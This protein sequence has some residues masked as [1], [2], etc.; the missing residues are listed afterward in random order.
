VEVAGRSGESVEF[1]DAEFVAVAAG[2][3][4]IFESWSLGLAT[5]DSVVAVDPVAFNA[6][7]GELSDLDGGVP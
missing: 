1:G 7:L 4:G 5:A 3:D 2:V 6:N